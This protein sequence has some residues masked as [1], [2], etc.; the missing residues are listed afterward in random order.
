MLLCFVAFIT[1]V[2]VSILIVR[3]PGSRRAS[4]ADSAFEPQ[5][6]H[7]GATPRIGGLAL[8]L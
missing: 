6:V 8:F 1:S 7:H 3:R 4:P 2:I 5:V